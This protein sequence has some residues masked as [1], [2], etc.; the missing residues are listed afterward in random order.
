MALPIL[1]IVN[2]LST[3]VRVVAGARGPNS[4]ANAAAAGGGITG[5]ALAMPLLNTLLDGIT[6]GAHPEIEKLGVLVGSLVAGWLVGRINKLITW[7]APKN[8]G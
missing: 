4:K 5:F 2:G 8:T 6:Q 1:A 7:L 3:V